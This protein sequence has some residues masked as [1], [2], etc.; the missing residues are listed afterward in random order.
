MSTAL[1]R[2]T[3]AELCECEGISRALVLQLVQ[4]DIAAPLAGSS[5]D[6]WEFDT[7]SAGWIRRAVRLQR[8]LDID[9]LAVAT[10]VDLLRERDALRRENREL[11]Q[12]LGRFLS[13]EAR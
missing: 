9:W 4:Y 3:V 7:S 8:D 12:R 1:R 5:V 13:D 2:I 10:L 11:R 6:N